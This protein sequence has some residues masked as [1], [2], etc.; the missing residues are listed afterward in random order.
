MAKVKPPSARMRTIPAPLGGWNARDALAG[1]PASDAVAMDNWFVDQFG[2]V[3]LR[4]GRTSHVTGLGSRVESLMEYAPPSN[5]NRLFAA[6]AG[7]I[8][9]VS[10]S[11]PVGAPVVTGL[12]NARLEHALISAL[13]GNFLVLG[14]GQDTPKKFDGSTWSDYT[15]TT[16]NA[17]LTSLAS[18][19]L[20]VNRL[21]WVEKGTLSAWYGEPASIGG[22]LTEFPMGA[23]FA[24][25]GELIAMASWT[26]DGGSGPDDYSVFLSSKGE[27][28]IYQGTDPSS[29]DGWSKVGL[30]KVAEP[31]GRRC[32]FKAG[33]DLG[34][35]TT[36]GLVLLGQ[37]L[38]SNVSGQSAVAVT[39]KILGA[40][41]SAAAAAQLSFGWQV[42]EYP[43]QGFILV[44]VPIQEGVEAHQFVLTVAKGTW[45]RWR[46]LPAACWSLF[47]S[48]PYFGGFDGT[49]YR[50]DP[51]AE[52][53]DGRPIQGFIQTAFGDFGTAAN[54]QFLMARPLFQGPPDF[55]PQIALKLEYDTTP[56]QTQTVQAS[57]TGPTWDEWQ[58]DL[59]PWGVSRA[60]TSQWQSLPGL[61][62]RASLAFRVAATTALSFNSVDVTYQIGGAL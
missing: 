19:A 34:I 52:A 46:D 48:N 30:F 32:L 9:D 13:G 44:N 14:N 42:V 57:G 54:K 12:A 35:L 25:G 5:A 37:I 45:G 4:G 27:V 24:R 40:F 49:V 33:A 59:Q 8:Y 43:G 10:A 56:P 6:A 2:E 16:G 22:T 29:T 50:Y 31:L 20:M 3:R 7:K 41:L 18:P 21:W 11:G 62:Q 53:D 51:F 38:D 39:N 60:P 23:V 47:G 26:R 61:G 36:Q 58:W 17:P 1:M 55:A 28:L 15:T